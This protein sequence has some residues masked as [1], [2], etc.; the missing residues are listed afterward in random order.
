MRFQGSAPTEVAGILQ[1]VFT[2][3]LPTIGGC[4]YND[5]LRILR[6]VELKATNECFVSAF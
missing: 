1:A 4:C 6:L 3:L 2:W 5:R